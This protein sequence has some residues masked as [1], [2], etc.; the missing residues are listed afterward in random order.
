[1]AVMMTDVGRAARGA[2]RY[3]RYAPDLAGELRL[4]EAGFPCVVTEISAAGAR[5]EVAR[6]IAD[7]ALAADLA[8]VI[9]SLG[10]YRARRVWRE[11][12]EAAYLFALTDHSMR[13]LDA[14]MA[15]RFRA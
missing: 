12:A 13:A 5:V 6:E 8:V 11:G 14:L 2:A 4:A 7:Q 9:P 1:M 10:Q 3:R 15:D